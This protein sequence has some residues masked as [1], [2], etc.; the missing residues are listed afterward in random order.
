P[1]K[2][3]DEKKLILNLKYIFPEKNYTEI[4]KKIKKGNFFYFEKKISN[5][6]YVKLM[7]LGDKSLEPRDNLTRIYP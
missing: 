4:K 2:I 1:S 7:Q 5:K 6:N 3:I